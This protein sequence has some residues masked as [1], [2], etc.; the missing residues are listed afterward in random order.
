MLKSVNGSLA[1]Q[2]W[3]GCAAVCTTSEM[4]LPNFAKISKTCSWSRMSTG[5]CLNPFND[6]SSCLVFQAVDASS[7]K[8]YRRMSLSMPTISSPFSCL[9]LDIS[10]PINPDEPVTTA[11]DIKGSPEKIS[12]SEIGTEDRLIR[13]H[14]LKNVDNNISN[15]TLRF[16][17]QRS[18][19][20]T[21]VGNVKWNVK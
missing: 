5:R 1:A 21:M 7:P 13:P 6:F 4:L 12:L 3:L 2:S 9:Y 19:S 11:T 15:R 20:P 14:P 8:K 17:T 10:L 18:R 16:P